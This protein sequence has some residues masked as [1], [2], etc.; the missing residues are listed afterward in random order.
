MFK[1]KTLD[2]NRKEWAIGFL[3]GLLLNNKCSHFILTGE[4]ESERIRNFPSFALEHLPKMTFV[5]SGEKPLAVYPKS[6]L[7]KK[8]TINCPFLFFFCCSN[9]A[10]I[11][12]VNFMS[13]F[14]SYCFTTGGI[15]SAHHCWPVCLRAKR[16]SRTNLS[17]LP[18]CRYA[19]TSLKGQE[20]NYIHLEASGLY[21]LLQDNS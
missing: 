4:N 13:C 20:F 1:L 2:T 14:I 3:L 12:S 18:L 9:R 10:P 16:P 19:T 17:L 6:C 7:H 5:L 15:S 8:W 21:S 11:S